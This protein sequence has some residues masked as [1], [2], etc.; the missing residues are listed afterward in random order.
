MSLGLLFRYELNLN[1]LNKWLYFQLLL[2]LLKRKI[3]ILFKT[4]D[5]L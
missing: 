2:K 4:Y 5:S 1:E 3:T